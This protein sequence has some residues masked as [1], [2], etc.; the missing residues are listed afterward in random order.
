MARAGEG[1]DVLEPFFLSL[2]DFL[3]FLVGE[4]DVVLGIILDA[5]S[6]LGGG[7]TRAEIYGGLFVVGLRG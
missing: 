1:E 6:V 5:N 3:G 7:D 4:A 2:D